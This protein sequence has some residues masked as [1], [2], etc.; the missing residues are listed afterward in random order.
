MLGAAARKQEGLWA[1]WLRITVTLPAAT[2]VVS[3][4]GLYLW[5]LGVWHQPLH[6]NGYGL[7][8]SLN[9]LYWT[10]TLMCASSFGIAILRNV[11]DRRVL[12][13][14]LGALMVTLELTPLMLE[15]TARFTYA[16]VS[17][18]YADYI[19]R[20]HALDVQHFIYLNWP[21]LHLLVALLVIFGVNPLLILMIG[22]VLLQ[23]VLVVLVHRIAC[24]ITG[25]ART[26]WAATGMFV[27]TSENSSYVLPATLGILLALTT[28]VLVLTAE[29]R[30]RERKSSWAPMGL[31]VLTGIAIVPTHLLS[32]I[33]L[34]LFLVGLV[35]TPSGLNKWTGLPVAAVAVALVVWQ[36]SV[37]AGWTA[38]T[39]PAVLHGLLQVSSTAAATGHFALGGSVAHTR[40]VHVRL[41]LY[42]LIALTA[43]TGWL[44]A[45]LSD[46]RHAMCSA[47]CAIGICC[48]FL[49]SL[50]TSY[51]GEI[52]SRAFGLA[53]PFMAVAAA[54]LV[55]SHAGRGALAVVALT[56]V[57]GYP[58]YAY[59]NEL[60]DYVSPAEIAASQYLINHMPSQIHL[61]NV[62]QRTIPMGRI[63]NFYSYAPHP[64]DVTFTGR[65]FDRA[66]AFWG[67][68]ARQ[69]G[70]IPTCRKPWYTNSEV[71]IYVCAVHHRPYETASRRRYSRLS[72]P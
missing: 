7:L 68:S 12:T 43:G 50:V 24:L 66:R 5:F 40:V 56:F 45:V 23:T 17:Y 64:V 70:M 53:M 11:R 47:V 36:G 26:S 72:L 13:F 61:T 67:T 19:V 33:Y 31:A 51:N 8:P 44:F 52:I 4:V 69:A 15:H 63:E 55:T 46:R 18:G 34:V 21:L 25:D 49:L 1:G 60:L 2:I 71:R 57:G 39:L 42:I 62:V 38:S 48:P 59:G 10:G 58:V 35:L 3:G 16:Y 65:P 30:R 28:L 6:L 32:S 22:P 20:H 27:V 14:A 41:A 29:R 37:A 9:V 54:L